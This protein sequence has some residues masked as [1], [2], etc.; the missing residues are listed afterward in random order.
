MPDIIS[1]S[2]GVTFR[3][4]V[5]SGSTGII[6]VINTIIVPIIFALAIA[7][8]IWGLAQYFLLSQGDEGK[9]EKGREFALWG[10]LG[11]IVLLSVWGL[12]NLL[13]STLGFAG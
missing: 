9:I 13:L 8:F 3:N 11:I 5:G 2:G 4:F 7:V 1:T 10:L 6:G 12:V